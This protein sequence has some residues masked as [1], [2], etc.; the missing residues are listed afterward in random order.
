M[1]DV[2]RRD[3]GSGAIY[4]RTRKTR[5]GGT[6]V[7]YE[8]AYEVDLGDGRRHRRFVSAPTQSQAARK[9]L[10]AQKRTRRVRA[11]GSLGDFLDRWL[12]TVSSELRPRTADGYRSI[13]DL[14]LRP[15]LGAIAMERL[16]VPDVQRFRARQLETHSTGA[17]RNQLACLRAALGRAVRWG[18]LE[19]NPAALVESPR[20]VRA[21]IHPLSADQARTFL[22]FV[23]GDPLEALYVL[24][25]TT[26]M[27]QGEL[28]GLHWPDIDWERG[29]LTVNRTLVRLH[30]V[31]SDGL[32]KTD[33]SRR[34]IPLSRMAIDALRAHQRAM[35]VVGA[36]Q[37][38]FCTTTGGPLANWAVTREFQRQIA[39]AGLPAQRFHDLRHAAASLLIS[40]GVDLA[41][42]RDLLGHSTIGTTV[43]IY[44]HLAA[45]AKQRAA[46]QMD[47]ALGGTR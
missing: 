39:L 12:D 42:I 10:D 2:S 19:R 22:A 45:E 1:E 31:Y 40:Q 43:N 13:I 14:H 20:V 16:S 37:L 7:V 27:R 23:H 32:P 4:E 17:V 33:L 11:G 5:D 25:L 26:G 28:L 18:I 9:L 6:R 24:A 44:G 21:T 8:G 30:G 47:R 34:T 3:W 36:R 46:D 29:T 15:A 38:V 35:T 41:V